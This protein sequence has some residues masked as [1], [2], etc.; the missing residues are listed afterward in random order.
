SI[1]PKSTL[2]HAQKKR[3]SPAYT[4]DWSQLPLVHATE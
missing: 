1:V 4:T 3:M 2:C